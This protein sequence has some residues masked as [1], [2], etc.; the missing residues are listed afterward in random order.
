MSSRNAT[1]VGDWDEAD[2]R[3]W[4]DAGYYVDEGQ[5]AIATRTT[6]F[7]RIWTGRA[8]IYI[9]A[10][11]LIAVSALVLVTRPDATVPS[12]SPAATP[13]APALMTHDPGPVIDPENNKP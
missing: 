4:E 8:M 1:A 5:P 11:G 9:L 2:L 12:A 10:A 3:D 13:A 7:Q 6:L